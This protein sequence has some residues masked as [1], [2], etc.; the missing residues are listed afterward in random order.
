MKYFRDLSPPSRPLSLCTNTA[1]SGTPWRY[2]WSESKT[3][4]ADSLL[5]N[6]GLEWSLYYNGRDYKTAQKGHGSAEKCQ[7]SAVTASCLLTTTHSKG[8]T[9]FS[10][11]QWTFQE[12]VQPH[13]ALVST[14][15]NCTLSYISCICHPHKAK[16]S[17][18]HHVF[19]TSTATDLQGGKLLKRSTEGLNK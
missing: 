17:L 10:E 5:G 8:Q 1:Y 9:S 4:R 15:W 12:I 7:C 3:A 6:E 11:N 19:I 16:H 13:F 18:S 14:K 2:N